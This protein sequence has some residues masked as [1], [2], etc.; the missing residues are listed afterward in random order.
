MKHVK[1]I[2]EFWSL[3]QKNKTEPVDMTIELLTDLLSSD[4]ENHSSYK[5]YDCHF[6]AKGSKLDK[7]NKADIY[8][9]L[10]GV[11]DNRSIIG[12][13]CKKGIILCSFTDDGSR[14][15][16]IFEIEKSIN[17]KRLKSY[18]IDFVLT[19]VHGSYSGI[20]FFDSYPAPKP[21]KYM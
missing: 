18:G 13:G 8:G 20:L 21:F 4:L 2:N 10:P 14:P 17:R 7:D 9:S 3:F 12:R 16:E 19:N 11:G 15:G 1:S 5:F 6:A